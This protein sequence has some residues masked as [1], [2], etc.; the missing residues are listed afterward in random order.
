M[1]KVVI[2][3][4]LARDLSQFLTMCPPEQFTSGLFTFISISDLWTLFVCVIFLGCSRGIW[5][6]PG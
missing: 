3:L 6:F 1:T 5:R 2:F 4:L